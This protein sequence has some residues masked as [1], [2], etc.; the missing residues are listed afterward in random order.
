MSIALRPNTGRYSPLYFLASLGA[1]GLAVTFFMYLMFWVPHPGQPVPV[2][3]DIAAAWSAGGWVSY[4]IPV[5]LLGIAVFAALNIWM[6]VANIAAYNR[7]AQTEGF[8]KLLASNANTQRL[9]MPLA[10]AMSINAGFILGLVFVPGLWGIVEYLFPLALIA[11]GAT[12]YLALRMIGQFLSRV[13]TEPDSFEEAAN[14][15]FAQMLPAFALS[16]VAVGFAAPAA[17]SHT[18]LTVAAGLIG[19]TFFAA[20]AVILAGIALIAGVIS[21]LR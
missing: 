8:D 6:L 19:S 18:P 16:M 20:G 9:A 7:F 13:L 3:E 10:F 15:S 21:M 11:F 17:M 5:A 1:G 4:A 2:F 14:A 12:G